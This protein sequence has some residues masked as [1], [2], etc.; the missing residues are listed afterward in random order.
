MASLA[1]FLTSRIALVTGSASG[2]GLATACAL[3]SRGAHIVLTD[4]GESFENSLLCVCVRVLFKN[5]HCNGTRREA[6][7][8]ELV[9]VLCCSFAATSP[10]IQEAVDD[11]SRAAA[12]AGNG[13]VVFFPADLRSPA[14]ISALF[15]SIQRHDFGPGME[16][17]SRPASAKTERRDAGVGA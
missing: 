15:Q 1:P 6:R 16:A 13:H 12:A 11:V 5:D 7:R 3:A 4:T 2:L 17:E 9:G 8:M 14:E 10:S